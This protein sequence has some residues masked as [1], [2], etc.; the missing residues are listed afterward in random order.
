MTKVSK[1]YFGFSRA[2]SISRRAPGSRPV[3]R[4]D[5]GLSRPPRCAGG[6]ASDRR[7]LPRS[8]LSD[9]RRAPNSLIRPLSVLSAADSDGADGSTVTATLTSR[10]I[11]A[12][13]AAVSAG[14]R[15]L[16]RTSLANSCGAA[17]TTV[18]ST[19]AIGRVSDNQAW[20]WG[21]TSPCADS[22]SRVR[23]HSAANSGPVSCTPFSCGADTHTPLTDRQ[24]LNCCLAN[25]R[26]AD[27]RPNI[28]H[29][30]LGFWSRL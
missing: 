13:S 12:A 1:V 15:R 18:S 10:P 6:S 29:R 3:P 23:A 9:S 26:S 25:D 24:L 28:R 22:R 11:S 4:C 20:N 8:E 21:V 14:R 16:S 7:S 30:Q 5:L 27:V 17:R 2:G 19:R